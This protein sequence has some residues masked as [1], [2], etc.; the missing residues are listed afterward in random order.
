MG[1]EITEKGYKIIGDIHRYINEVKET[2][3]STK[4]L[5]EK[6][7]KEK[8]NE[9]KLLKKSLSKNN[10]GNKDLEIIKLREKIREISAEND[11]NYNS[12]IKLQKGILTL[13]ALYPLIESA[14]D[15]K[16][17]YKAEELFD[18]IDKEELA[19]A[20]E[21]VM[22]GL[23]EFL[24]IYNEKVDPDFTSKEEFLARNIEKFNF[25][26]SVIIKEKLFKGL[27]DNIDIFKKLSENFAV[28]FIKNEVFYGC[29]DNAKY[30]LGNIFNI[31]GTDVRNRQ[32]K[33][34]ILIMSLYLGIKDIE[35]SRTIGAL[36]K[37]AIKSSEDLRFLNF[38]ANKKKIKDMSFEKSNEQ[39]EVLDESVVDEICNNIE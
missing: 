14:I 21:S 2:I 31:D 35:E 20:D 29:E 4:R 23:I 17:F 18:L 16:Y 37:K 38:I 34:Y 11:A 6:K 33:E 28:D 36:Y 9:I 19:Q 26:N 13:K 39:F 32:N 25:K 7:L 1:R 8:D 24:K 12:F 5:D 15:N 30:L 10:Q 27:L 22:I 3:E